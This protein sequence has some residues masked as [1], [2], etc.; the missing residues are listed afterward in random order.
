MNCTGFTICPIA[1]LQIF[2]IPVLF[3][4]CWKE[5]NELE[6]K[7]EELMKSGPVESKMD[8]DSDEDLNEEALDEF[9]DWRSKK[10]WR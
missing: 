10:S 4:Q 2:L 5:V 8:V 7:K 3:S 1:S 9:L 6:T